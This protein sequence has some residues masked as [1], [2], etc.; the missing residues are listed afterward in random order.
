MSKILSGKGSDK[1]KGDSFN[2]EFPF[3]LLLDYVS[4]LKE[5]L[6]SLYDAIYVKIL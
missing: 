6:P 1:K 5:A 3:H 2:K 4:L